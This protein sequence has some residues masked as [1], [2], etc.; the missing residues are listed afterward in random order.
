[1]TRGRE[2]AACSVTEN[3]KRADSARM[4]HLHHSS[5]TRLANTEAPGVKR[6]AEENL[7]RG[8]FGAYERLGIHAQ[9]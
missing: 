2:N 8:T 3:G 9:H 1:M 6:E 4:L 5:R 7:P